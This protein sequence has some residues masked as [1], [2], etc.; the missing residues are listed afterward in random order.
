MSYWVYTDADDCGDDNAAL[1]AL[2]VGVLTLFGGFPA[3]AVY[4]RQRE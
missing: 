4:V 1:W 3:L 2:A